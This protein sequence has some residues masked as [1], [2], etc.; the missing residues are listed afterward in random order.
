MF[1]SKEGLPR[2]WLK[3][4]VT[5]VFKNRGQRS[6]PVNYRPI[7]VSSLLYKLTSSILLHKLQS[8]LEDL[9]LKAPTALGFRK[10]KGT[11][12]A[13]WLLQHCIYLACSPRN[14]G[15]YGGKLFAC[16]IDFRASL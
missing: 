6:D 10:K 9:G 11:E 1:H 13:I 8:K 16:F 12:Q 15:G 5:P 14:K 7:T 3:A 2:A 4:Y